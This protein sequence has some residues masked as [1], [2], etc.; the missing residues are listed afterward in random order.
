MKKLIKK[1]LKRSLEKR[2]F[3]EQNKK[4]D[5]NISELKKLQNEGAIIVDVRS[6]QEYKEG[7]ID[8]AIS[9]P[10]YEIKKTGEKLL[11]NKDEKIILYCSSGTRS[12]KA[13]KILQKL[14]YKSVFNLYEGYNTSNFELL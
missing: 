5:I 6:P 14:G 3:E 8:G 10:E 4:Y 11:K 1:F 7:H 9:I 12:K 13:Q 2:E